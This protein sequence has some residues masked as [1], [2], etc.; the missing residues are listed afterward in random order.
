MS[1]ERSLKDGR[2]SEK[3]QSSFCVLAVPLLAV[4]YW[5]LA[6]TFGPFRE[7]SSGR[8]EGPAACRQNADPFPS[9]SLRVGM[10]SSTKFGLEERFLSFQLPTPV[11]SIRRL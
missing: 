8:S 4:S 10:T 11:P 2:R 9:A 7:L 5:L 1:H 6:R 3:C